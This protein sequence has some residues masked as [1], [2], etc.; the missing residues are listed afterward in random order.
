MII[1]IAV[2]IGCMFYET[3][4]TEG[5]EARQQSTQLWNKVLRNETNHQHYRPRNFLQTEIINQAGE[6]EL[7]TRKYG[8]GTYETASLT[9]DETRKLKQHQTSTDTRNNIDRL[10]KEVDRLLEEADQQKHSTST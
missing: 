10:I 9:A 8:T 5:K 7:I 1:V 4:T 6:G 3:Y 2:G